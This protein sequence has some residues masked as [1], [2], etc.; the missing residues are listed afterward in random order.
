MRPNA[1]VCLIFILKNTNLLPVAVLS[2]GG[3]G[4]IKGAVTARGRQDYEG[5]NNGDE[6]SDKDGADD[7]DDGWDEEGGQRRVGM[8]PRT[9]KAT[10]MGGG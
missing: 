3:T 5:R 6:E 4:R 9:G 1:N 8:G 7:G 10:R 2:Q